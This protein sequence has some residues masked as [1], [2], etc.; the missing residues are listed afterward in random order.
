MNNRNKVGNNSSVGN[1]EQ[2]SFLERSL[3]YTYIYI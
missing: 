2:I 3:T 1:I